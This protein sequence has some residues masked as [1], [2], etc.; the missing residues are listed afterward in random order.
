MAFARHLDQVAM[1]RE[2]LMETTTEGQRYHRIAHAM[3]LEDRRL[4]FPGGEIGSEPIPHQQPHGQPRKLGCGHIC[5]GAVSGIE[6]DRRY[7]NF[8]RQHH[9]NAA[10]KR[11]ANEHDPPLAGPRPHR[12]IGAAGVRHQ[13]IFGRATGR[14]TIATPADGHDAGAILREQAEAIGS[15]RQIPA[16]AMEVQVNRLARRARWNPPDD[17]IFA[18]GRRQMLE[19]GILQAHVRRIRQGR[20]RMV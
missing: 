2:Q 11:F 6:N 20:V 7:R 3:N 15:V 9:R 8:R 10:S 1:N 12:I 4:N 13:P 5:D 18:I 17:E 19:L 14:A 16:V